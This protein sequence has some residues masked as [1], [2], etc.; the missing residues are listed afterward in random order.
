[1]IIYE[2]RVRAECTNEIRPGKICGAHVAEDQTWCPV[3][4]EPTLSRRVGPSASSVRLARLTPIRAATRLLS[5]DE[6][7]VRLRAEAFGA[8][9][10]FERRSRR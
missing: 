7:R 2:L 5:S 10:E 8:S 9:S 4:G 6:T 3:C 1:M